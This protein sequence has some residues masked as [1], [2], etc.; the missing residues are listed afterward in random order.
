MRVIKLALFS[1]PCGEV[2]SWTHHPKKKKN[3]GEY[4]VWGPSKQY[5]LSLAG[6]MPRGMEYW[7]MF[8]W[9]ECGY[10]ISKL[11]SEK[12]TLCLEEVCGPSRKVLQYSSHLEQ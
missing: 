6:V 3:D 2:R 11:M 10:W 9:D 5:K 7:V 8:P 4:N 12:A 1:M